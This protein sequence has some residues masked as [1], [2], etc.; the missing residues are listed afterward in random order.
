MVLSFA[1]SRQEA[2]VS[3]PAPIII[4]NLFPR[5]VGHMGRWAAH[6]GRAR[7]MGF[8]WIYVN[9]VQYPGFSGSLYAVKDHHRMNPLFVPPG[10]H[11]GMGEL[12][13]TIE[14]LH[15]QGLRVMMDLVINHTAKDSDLT[16]EHPEWYK[17]DEK[18]E[19]LSPFAIDPA[20]ARKKT[21]WGDLAEI[22]NKDTPDREGLW[23]YWGELLL[24]YQ[25][26]GFDGFRCDAA[27]KVP[28]DLW[29][30]L[31]GA[32]RRLRPEAVFCAETLGCRI[33][34]VEQ[35]SGAGFDFLFNSSKWWAFD[36]PWCLE[37]HEEFGKIAP[38]IAFPE[39]HD[40]ERLMDESGG[41]VQV[42]KQRY[43]FAAVFS[44]GLLMP[45]GYELGFRKSV[46]VVRTIPE[47]WEETG[48]DLSPFV[49]EVNRLKAQTPIL[50]VEGHF[51]VVG[52]LRGQTAVLLKRQ[53]GLDPALI[54]VNKDKH[55]PQP[56]QLAPL[57]GRLPARGRGPRLLRP[58]V[59]GEPLPLPG[60]GVLSLE[61]AE[62]ALVLP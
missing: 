19:V 56:L 42:Q 28:G 59:G 52:D 22:D 54:L 31:I 37:Q 44:A 16:L 36:E 6:A 57:A 5:L 9:P 8:N 1:D 35:L 61:P 49:R 58:F 41:M 62:I 55:A 3:A 25:K 38:S 18:G 21:V 4:Y 2:V 20:D 11:D 43:L 12:R 46:N 14:T 32:A 33:A 60:S 34:E 27:Y 48:L 17:R 7:E 45:I 53:E 50:G 24:Y 10:V 30:R 15:H 40:T 23:R 29:K 39:S 47:D 51:S 13:A 26:L